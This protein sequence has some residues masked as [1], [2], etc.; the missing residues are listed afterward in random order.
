MDIESPELLVRVAPDDGVKRE[1]A[2]AAEVTMIPPRVIA[3][4]VLRHC[5]GRF[6]EITEEA[7]AEGSI[8]PVLGYRVHQQ[9]APR[10]RRRPTEKPAERRRPATDREVAAVA[11]RRRRER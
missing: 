9:L 4:A 11:A 6:Q 2:A 8:G 5:R 7:L 1:L 10:P 3:A